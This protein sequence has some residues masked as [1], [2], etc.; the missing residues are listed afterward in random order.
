MIKVLEK[1]KD[2]SYKLFKGPGFEVI[3]FDDY[4]WGKPTILVKYAGGIGW[5][6]KYDGAFAELVGSY[7][8]SGTY[9]GVRKRWFKLYNIFNEFL[10][11]LLNKNVV[12]E[13]NLWVIGDEA[14]ISDSTQFSLLKLSQDSIKDNDT[15]LELPKRRVLSY[16]YK[17]EQ[18]DTYIIVD[19]DE[20]D[21]SLPYN[22]YLGTIDDYKKLEEVEEKE[23]HKCTTR[24]FKTSDGDL[25]TS[26]PCSGGCEISW[27]S[28]LGYHY[29]LV[30]MSQTDEIGCFLKKLNIDE[31]IIKY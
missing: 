20:F 19:M 9:N 28:K 11:K 4:E 18:S 6:M 14:F 10:S 5:G 21:Y 25:Y 17:F 7:K 31:R 26:C 8:S 1:Y 2:R 3:I 13:V 24:L 16:L 27:T 30:E 29:K 23:V 12:F 15:L 22:I